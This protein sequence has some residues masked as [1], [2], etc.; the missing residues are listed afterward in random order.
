V[1][2]PIP[3]QSRRQEEDNRWQFYKSFSG[4]FT[5]NLSRAWEI[6]LYRC[7][8]RLTLLCEIILQTTLFI[9]I[10]VLKTV[11]VFTCLLV[12]RVKKEI[13][14]NCSRKFSLSS[15]EFINVMQIAVYTLN[16]ISV[17]GAVRSDRV[18]QLAH[19]VENSKVTK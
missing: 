3:S 18:I 2:L 6:E 1:E 16:P 8:R 9:G 13:R 19:I 4:S 7:K 11:L 12:H 10:F 14:S 15:L 5:K 17:H